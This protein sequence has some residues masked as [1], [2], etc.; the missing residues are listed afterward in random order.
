MK[1]QRSEKE[2][3]KQRDIV[4]LNWIL[5]T[6]HQPTLQ[7]HIDTGP[8]VIENRLFHF[9]ESYHGIFTNKLFFL[10]DQEIYKYVKLLHDNWLQTLS[11]DQYYRSTHNSNT[12]VFSNPM[13]LPLDDIQEEAWKAIDEALY[14]M[15]DALDKINNSVRQK[16]LEINIDECNKKAWTEYI[17]FKKEMIEK[18]E[19]DDV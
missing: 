7:E 19:D 6:I 10:Y 16:Y 11:F 1:G 14:K 3:K 17:D 18:F 4:N 9:W 2:T 13:D 5:S 8:R 15:N 12:Y